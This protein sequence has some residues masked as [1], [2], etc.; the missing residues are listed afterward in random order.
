MLHDANVIVGTAVGSN[1]PASA[2]NTCGRF[3]RIGVGG[4]VVALADDD[5]TANTVGSS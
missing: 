3:A 4:T 1:A 2:V 5:V